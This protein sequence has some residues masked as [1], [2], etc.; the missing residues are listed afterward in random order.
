MATAAAPIERIQCKW[1]QSMNEKTAL[2]CHACGAQLDVR[3]VVSESGWREAP[4]LKDMVELQFGNS[5]C[6]AEGEI[7]PVAEIKLTQGDSIY[8]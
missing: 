8:F 7:V 5:T 3:D 1:C 2:S 4:R 6:Q